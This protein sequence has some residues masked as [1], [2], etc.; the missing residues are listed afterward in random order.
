MIH[1]NYD[2]DESTWV[3]EGLAELAMW[4]FGNPDTV[5]SFN[6]NPDDS[7]VTWG[8]AWADY[9][10]TYLWTL[11][12]F[13]QYG[14]Q[15]TVWDVVHQP[16]NGMA[17]YLAAVT[18]QGYAVTM[19]DV[20]G[21]WS[22]ANYLDDTTVPD[23]RY[24]YTGETLPPFL[25]FVTHDTVPASGSGSVES[26]AT[27]YIRVTTLPG[28]PRLTFNGV[29]SGLFRV[30][31]IALDPVQ[32]SLVQAVPL[33]GANDGSL[34]LAA[35]EGYQEVVVSVASVSGLA[36]STYSYTVDAPSVLFSDDFESS[37]TTNWSATVP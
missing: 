9:I 15:P 11:Y 32:P 6:T 35:A 27:D 2:T 8:S 1:Y 30:V 26:W 21:D 25:P 24:G 10:Q 12:A 19:E 20:Y 34:E 17:G 23:G 13:E 31:L 18:G 5:S 37:G 7:L 3:E 29:D 22:V 14:G 33:D 36:S 16:A 28:A 4:L